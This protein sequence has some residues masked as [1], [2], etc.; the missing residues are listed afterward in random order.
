M[1]RF[2][3]VF[4]VACLLS[5]VV[6]GLLTTSLF[7]KQKVS[8]SALAA[9]EE[10]LIPAAS[11]TRCGVLCNDICGA[12][13]YDPDSQKCRLISGLVMEQGDLGEQ[14]GGQLLHVKMSPDNTLPIFVPT[15]TTTTATTAS[16]TTNK[17]KGID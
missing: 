3:Q 6:E 9:T 8:Q 2:I 4:V 1:T 15:T 16:T 12:F 11:L 7:T 14:T 17:G 13:S 10:R 5:A